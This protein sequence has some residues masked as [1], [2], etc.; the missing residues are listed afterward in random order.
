MGLVSFGH[1][2]MKIALCNMRT[3][4]IL[5]EMSQTGDGNEEGNAEQCPM[6]GGKNGDN[7]STGSPSTRE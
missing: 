4:I 2:I 1:W 6:S 3:S 5:K 7:V